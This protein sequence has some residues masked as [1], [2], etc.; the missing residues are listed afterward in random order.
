MSTRLGL[1]FLVLTAMLSAT[2]HSSSS[3][4]QRVTIVGAGIGEFVHTV[5]F[6]IQAICC[7]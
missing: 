4:Y 5:T 3:T 6:L 7:I 1:V 2:S